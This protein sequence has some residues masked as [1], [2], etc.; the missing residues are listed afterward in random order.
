MPT[1][2]IL[3]QGDEVVTGQIADTNAAYLSERL[4]ELG[5]TVTRHTT[6]GDRLDDLR[7]AL[8]EIARRADVCIGTG[9]LGP[10]ADDLTADAVARAFDRPLV[11]D[12]EAMR[13]IEAMYSRFKR[14]MPEIN[15]KQAW[16]P[17]GSLP[18]YNAWGTAPGFAVET[19]RAWMAFM[20]GVPREMH[21]MFK[22]RVEPELRRRFALR[23]GRLVT[24]RT[25]GA[26]E[27]DLQQRVAGFTHPGVVLG[28]RTILPENWIKLRFESDVEPETVRQ[29][30][31]EV[32][33]RVGSP[34]F[35]IE[36]LP[37]HP[38]AA[39][40]GGGLAHVVGRLLTVRAETLTVA[41]SC[42]GGR[43]ASMCTA[44]PGSSA[45]FLD[46]VVVYANA[47]KMRLLGV[48]SDTLARHG[49]V[50]P[51]VAVEMARG[52]Q[53]RSGATYALSITGIAGPDG[54]TPGKP[55]GT[56]EVALAT[57]DGVESRTFHLGGDRD[58][59]QSLSAAGALDLLRRRLQGR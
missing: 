38:L 6:V 7:D 16:L 4:T 25:T 40:A 42:T 12:E 8:C 35:A 47:A 27:S 28:F 24:L 32:A 44:V 50:S 45:W 19:E 1:A 10:T 30:T 43:V 37:D 26:G 9:G 39:P 14:V 57:A 59:I 34:L 17:G 33:S 11:F 3:S 56:V 21:A 13:Q 15:R 23:A 58:R 51:E 52:A 2:E 20:P 22:E 36:G 41:E 54:G 18:L 49:A 29:L 48:Q 5:F 53:T 46:G 55:V 31:D